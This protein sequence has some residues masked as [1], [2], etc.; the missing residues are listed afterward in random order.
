M[1]RKYIFG[2]LIA[3]IFLT[4][5]SYLSYRTMIQLQTTTAQ[6]IQSHRVMVS[7]QFILSLT[8]GT[9]ADS[10]G[11]GL[12]GNP[13]FLESA[14]RSADSLRME[15]E[16]LR[17]LT[18]A[19]PEHHPQLML[20]EELVNR[21]LDL[22][23]EANRIRTLGGVPEAVRF[24]QSGKGQAAT[25]QIK[26]I[27]EEMNRREQMFLLEKSG[28]AAESFRTTALV[29]LAGN[30]LGLL[31]LGFVFV[32]ITREINERRQIQVA[33]SESESNYRQLVETAN[34]IIY[35]TDQEGRF[36]YVN[37]V[38]LRITGYSEEET[39]GKRYVEVIYERY[40]HD[41][42]RYYKV[43]AL[44]QELVTYREVPIVKKN[45]ELLWLGQNV[46][47]L[48]ENGSPVGFQA[49]ARDIT[50]QHRAESER[51]RV[52]DMSLD[53]LCVT[54]TKGFILRV[55]SAWEQ[56]LGFHESKLLS[57][58][59]LNFVHPDDRSK[60]EERFREVISG[61][62]LVGFE[63]RFVT[64]EGSPRWIE[65]SAATDEAEGIIYA[66]GRDVTE[67]KRSDDEIRRSEARYRILAE[68]ATD[69]I[70][71]QT[72]DGIYLYVSP[73]CKRIL[74][75][76][77]EELIGRSAFDLFHP[78]DF[79]KAQVTR[80]KTQDQPETTT[81][82]YR[83]RTK[84]GA[85][86]WFE[87]TSR[88][89]KDPKCGRVKEVVSVSRDITFRKSIEQNL[90]ESEQ[91]L[92][93]IIETVQE[94][95]TLSDKNG[96]F[97]I[98]NSAMEHLTGYTMAEANGSGDFSRLL[99]PDENDRQHALDGLKALLESGRSTEL[100]TTIQTKRGELR[101][102]LVSTAIVSFRNET[103]FLSAYRDITE[104]KKAEEELKAA[105]EVA[106]AATRTKS[107]FLAVMSHEIRTP[108]NSVI[109][110]TDL[111][112]HTMLTDEQRDFVDTIRNSGESLLT[113]IND[114]LD[115]SKIESGKI[116]L[117]E[118]PCEPRTCIEAVLDLLTPKALQKGIDLLYWVDPKVPHYIVGD[119]HRLRQILINLV[120]NAVKFTE[121]GEVFVS[122]DISWKLDEQLELKFSV[123]DTGVGIPGD[124]IDRL[125]KAFSQVDTSTTRKFG[126]TGLGLAI[127]MRLTQLM[128]GKIWAE[129]ELGNG[130]TFFFTIKAKTP[131]P[132]FVQPKV[133]A[134]AKVPELSGKRAL[135]VDDNATNL[136]I[137]RSHCENWGMIVRTTPLPTEAIRWI[138]SGDPFDI[139]IL[140]MMI[141][142]MDGVLLAKELR[143][144]RTSDALPL[145]L[146]SSAG[147]T[148]SEVGS[149]DLFS[150]AI[151]KPVKHDQLFDTLMAALGGGKRRVPKSQPRPVD[152]LADRMPLSILAAEDNLVNQKLLQRVLKE[153][154]YDADIVPN[155]VEVVSAIRRKRYDLIFMDVHMPEMDGLEASRVLVSI[156]PRE[157][158]PVIVAVT[159]DALQ[160]DREKCMQA[161]MDDYITKP[162]RIADI[163]SVIERWSQTM[164]Q[165]HPSQQSI[166]DFPADEDIEKALGDRIRQL[167]LETDPAF[168]VELIDSYA[169]LFSNQSRAIEEACSANDEG[170]LRY[171]AHSLKGASL[172]IG[173][174][175]LGA[176]CKSIEDF[177]EA[178]DMASVE[179]LIPA[180]KQIID[181]TASALEIIKK[182]LSE[183]LQAGSG[184]QQG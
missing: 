118:R 147:V 25:E 17:A 34:D 168:V 22:I 161:G 120:G 131:P 169:P 64:K 24:T 69:V 74:G 3:L 58:P 156:L 97:E 65:W 155:G 73:A 72:P 141:P 154:G 126:G 122:A 20:L 134:R 177:A 5:M 11:Y 111:L 174:N 18:A 173:A 124:K 102:L 113:I 48:I 151:A 70:S 165:R 78:D 88:T 164:S 170:K 144:L 83:I 152:R 2:F 107:E 27:L 53:L 179:K 159:A 80:A 108:M 39:L 153:I 59:F 60:T 54:D 33:L 66:A 32:L 51:D 135:I 45:G 43:Q 125:F 115:F 92:Q 110:M 99:Y 167:G 85:Y 157:E 160:G 183:E 132:G 7:V 1:S 184:N 89:V 68:N 31:L 98:F 104:R 81:L 95:I 67:R 14:N 163:Q 23:Q 26:S 28:Q 166:P 36:T 114:I 137:L 8:R 162:I 84:E 42:E 129:S 146:L 4:G 15:L 29:F 172:N 38:G 61:K 75:Y 96:Q 106:E 30:G 145:V 41:I 12:S 138:R 50:L 119:E 9:E 46:Q 35:R 171:A 55:N 149:D 109:G 105:K 71:R 101:T 47:L 13:E 87:T 121:R 117:E 93:Q 76:D 77:P 63:T 140:D 123:R 136:F 94:G 128:G 127:S 37:P 181:K 82:L 139:G 62:Q 16:N 52:F 143:A 6:V 175:N 56:V 100:E 142:E 90:M 116:D 19:D 112:S 91:R 86:L 133:H 44:R 176:I 180:L 150:A 40:R 182:R 21:R 10:R 178:K 158:R 79:V 130:S 57:E 148:A 49:V 103:M